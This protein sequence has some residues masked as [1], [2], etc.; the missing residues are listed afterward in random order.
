MKIHSG[1]KKKRQHACHA[2]HPRVEV[3]QAG[4]VPDNLPD[5]KAP[6]YAERF[7]VLPI[8]TLSVAYIFATFP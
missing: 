5:K 1:K 4:F 2:A 3:L 7:A 6:Q 8:N